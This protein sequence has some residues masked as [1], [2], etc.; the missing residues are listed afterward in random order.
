MLTVFFGN[1]LNLSIFVPI[2]LTRRSDFGNYVDLAS[3]TA[4][5]F[6]N[7]KSFSS[8]CFVPFDISNEADLSFYFVEIIKCIR[9]TARV[10]EQISDILVSKNIKINAL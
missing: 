5:P 9:V 10:L 1:L 6:V 8:G 3:G 2:K 4:S 7:L